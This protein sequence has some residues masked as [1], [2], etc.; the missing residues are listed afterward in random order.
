MWNFIHLV[1]RIHNENKTSAVYGGDGQ[2]LRGKD[3]NS[4]PFVFHSKDA[5]PSIDAWSPTSS[6]S[7]PSIH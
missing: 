5:S 2:E 1:R 6:H 7:P 3:L 4:T